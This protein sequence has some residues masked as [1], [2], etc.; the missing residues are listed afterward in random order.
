MRI[1]V[2]APGH[3]FSTLDVFSGVVA[4]LRANG[5]EVWEYPLHKTFETMELLVASAKKVGIAPEG[6][7][8]DPLQLGTMGIPGYAM[9]KRVELVLFIHGLNVPPSIPET[10]RRGGYKTAILCTESPYETAEK[11]AGAAAFYET[12]FTTDKN[13]P[14]LFILNRPDRV[15]YLPHAWHPG[16]HAPDG[17]KA[18]PCDVFFVGTRYEERDE[19]LNGVDWTGIDFRDKTLDYSKNALSEL[20]TQITPNE[21][22]AAHY[23]S[24]FISLNHHR[25]STLIHGEGHIPSGLAYSLNPRAYEVPACG[26]FLV[27]DARAE[28]DDVFE[29]CVPTYTDSASLENLI[30]Y[31]LAHPDERNALA[32]AQHQAIQPHSWVD[33]AK[34]L[35][36][37]I[38]A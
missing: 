28:L 14:P 16:R 17:E 27:S 23:R 6:D 4:G 25:T 30:R 15:H 22:T 31:F 21:V 8:P 32:K 2:V 11:E 35:L 20:M 3:G 37:H 7:Y 34:D 18:D 26:G 13:A 33:R 1:L 12:V 10:L 36:T 29:G 9:A 5:Q 19:L 24:A 38:A